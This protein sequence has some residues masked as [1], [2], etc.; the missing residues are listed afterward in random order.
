MQNIYLETKFEDEMML[1]KRWYK[2]K[3]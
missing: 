3:Q 2:G 1:K